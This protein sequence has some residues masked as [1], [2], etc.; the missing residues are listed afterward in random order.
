MELNNTTNALL[1]AIEARIKSVLAEVA[2]MRESLAHDAGSMPG[3]VSHLM[4]VRDH[5]EKLIPRLEGLPKTAVAEAI[6]PGVS[7][8]IERISFALT[9]LQQEVEQTTGQAANGAENLTQAG[10]RA[11]DD[12]KAKADESMQQLAEAVRSLRTLGDRTSQSAAT[13]SASIARATATATQQLEAA[14]KSVV[15]ALAV[16]TPKS[17]HR[18]TAIVA[19]VGFVA[20]L[21]AGNWTHATHADTSA[22]MRWAASPAGRSAYAFDQANPG[23]GITAF[24]DCDLPGWRRSKLNHRS[25]CVVAIERHQP[26]GWFLPQPQK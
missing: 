8:T 1:T 16:A 22:I 12:T 9:K 19:V 23:R 5:L 20:I 17:N 25:A 6:A 10:I 21:F 18:L 14:T 2:A 3:V 24:A 26:Y 13:A 11:I 7:V 15:E 4:I